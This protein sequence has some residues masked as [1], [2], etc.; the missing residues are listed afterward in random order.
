MGIS[1]KN[2]LS[3][4]TTVIIINFINHQV[5]NMNS[6]KGETVVHPPVI[7]APPNEVEFIPP[8]FSNIITD[9]TA[10]VYQ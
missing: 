3:D 6:F 10:E 9:R 7:L 4:E 8:S 2:P 5:V 1:E